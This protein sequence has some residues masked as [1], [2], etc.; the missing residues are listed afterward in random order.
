[1]FLKDFTMPQIAPLR[2]LRL[3]EK[4]MEKK[5]QRQTRL[6]DVRRGAVSGK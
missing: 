4:W 6:T 1:M 2:N 5:T 3:K